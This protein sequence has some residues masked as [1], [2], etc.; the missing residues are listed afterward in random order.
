[1]LTTII[2]VSIAFAGGA[3]FDNLFFRANP[4][5]KQDVDKFIAKARQWGNHV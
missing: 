4:K 1:M 3:V 2:L 5:K